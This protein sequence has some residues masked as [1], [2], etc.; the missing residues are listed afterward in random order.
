MR[1]VAVILALVLLSPPASAQ[2]LAPVAV[3][4]PVDVRASS[5]VATR[6][7]AM[8]D[9]LPPTRYGSRLGHVMEGAVIGGV[10]GAIVGYA[11]GA[12]DDAE[13]PDSELKNF[14][15]TI[16]PVIF[17]ALGFTVGALVGMVRDA[18]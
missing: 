15:K 4:A 14:G 12:K 3:R 11:Y 18:D 17:G 2:R 7:R 9:T 6:I 1:L 16:G 5:P 8:M 10:F 13:H